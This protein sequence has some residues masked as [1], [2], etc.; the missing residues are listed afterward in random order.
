MPQ[1]HVSFS[2]QS[3]TSIMGFNPLSTTK[4]IKI[5]FAIMAV[6]PVIVFGL[7][8]IAVVVCCN[9]LSLGIEPF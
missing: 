9:F 8:G 5:F 4:N 2:V 7:G 3:E 6:T 1:M